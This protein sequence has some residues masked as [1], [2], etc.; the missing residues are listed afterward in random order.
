MKKLQSENQNFKNNIS[1]KIL[2][3]FKILNIPIQ[4]KTPKI[5]SLVVQIVYKI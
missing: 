1:V 2:K 4:I 5:I 3:N